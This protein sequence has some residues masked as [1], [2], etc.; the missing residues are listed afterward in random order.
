[1]ARIEKYL[2]GTSLHSSVQ[3]YLNQI[4]TGG[5]KLKTA[6]K[7]NKK[8]RQMLRT[9]LVN[10][11][12]PFAWGAKYITFRFLFYQVYCNEY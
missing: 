9:N 8:M 11:R 10:Y 5:N 4:R 3:P 7:L 1:V 12:Q 6:M 2:D